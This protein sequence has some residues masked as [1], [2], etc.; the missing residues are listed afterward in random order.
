MKIIEEKKEI[1]VLF[2]GTVSFRLKGNC[3]V[4]E[5]IVY[6]KINF[7]LSRTEKKN[8]KIFCFVLFRFASHLLKYFQ[9]FNHLRLKRNMFLNILHIMLLKKDFLNT[10]AFKNVVFIDIFQHLATS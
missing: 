4:I 2:N 8:T 1:D 7:Y 5:N 9:L 6:L 3:I 10:F